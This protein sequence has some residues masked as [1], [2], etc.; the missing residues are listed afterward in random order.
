LIDHHHEAAI[1]TDD[2]TVSAILDTRPVV[3]DAYLFAVLDRMGAISSSRLIEAIQEHRFGF[4]VLYRPMDSRYSKAL[5][6]P[7]VIEAIKA[8]YY[9]TTRAGRYSVLRPT[10]RTGIKTTN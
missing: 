4:V 8:N 2:P 5:F 7:R 6:G 9:E 3:L 1:L 10:P